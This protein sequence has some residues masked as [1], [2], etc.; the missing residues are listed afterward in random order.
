MAQALAR[1]EV[2]FLQHVGQH[3]IDHYRN[4][5]A[6]SGHTVAAKQLKK[7]GVPFEVALAIFGFRSRS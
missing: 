3:F 5:A 4:R 7:Q 2:G 1:G 6:E